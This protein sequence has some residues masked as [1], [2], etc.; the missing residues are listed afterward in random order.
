[1]EDA[2]MAHLVPV[3]DS[4][5]DFR[6]LRGKIGTSWRKPSASS[7]VVESRKSELPE[8]ESS[9]C[10]FSSKTAAAAT[11]SSTTVAGSVRLGAKGL[12]VPERVIVD[13]NRWFD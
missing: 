7:R 11:V 6:V 8:E 10:H 5:S 13:C 4:P 3:F 1:M 2:S 12:R 9:G